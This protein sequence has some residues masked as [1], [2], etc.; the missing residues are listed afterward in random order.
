MFGYVVDDNR[1]GIN[2]CYGYI[3]L[4]DVFLCRFVVGGI[5]R[6]DSSYVIKVVGVN[7]V[8]KFFC[9]VVIKVISYYGYLFLCVF[10]GEV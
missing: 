2:F 6:Y 5:I 8:D 10:Y 1:Y 4:I 9:V 3:M 7:F